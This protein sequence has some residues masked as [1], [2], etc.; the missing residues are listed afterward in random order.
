MVRIY[1]TKNKKEYK[2]VKFHLKIV[3]MGEGDI[4]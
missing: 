4:K 3:K 2:R 1:M